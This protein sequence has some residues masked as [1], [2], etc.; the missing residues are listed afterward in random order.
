MEHLDVLKQFGITSL[1]DARKL[2]ELTNDIVA[3]LEAIDEN[4]ND[5]DELAEH[6]S[7]IVANLRVIGEEA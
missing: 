1:E 7:A 2:A 4:D 6:T 5:L 3:S